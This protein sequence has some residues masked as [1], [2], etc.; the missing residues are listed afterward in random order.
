MLDGDQ[1][2]VPHPHAG[3]N[4]AEAALP[5][6][7]AHSVSALEADAGLLLMLSRLRVAVVVALVVVVVAGVIF[8]IA[9]P[10]E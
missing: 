4:G 7:L 10:S 1:A 2:P 6:H 5:Q 9:A 8:R 3:V